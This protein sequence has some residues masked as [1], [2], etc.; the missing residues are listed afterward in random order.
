M[1][2]LI[3]RAILRAIQ[4]SPSA[5]KLLFIGNVVS[6]GRRESRATAASLLLRYFPRANEKGGQDEVLRAPD[7]TPN[8]GRYSRPGRM[9]GP[10][11]SGASARG[12]SATTERDGTHRCKV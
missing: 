6:Y 8:I 2:V 9:F 11:K 5:R 4:D 1:R 3:Q 7:A 10:T 12:T